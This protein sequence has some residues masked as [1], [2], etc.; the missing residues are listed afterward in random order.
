MLDAMGGASLLEGGANFWAVKLYRRNPY[1][2]SM[3]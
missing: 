1:Q 3:K 2:V